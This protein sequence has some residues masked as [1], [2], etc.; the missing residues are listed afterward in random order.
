MPHPE[1]TLSFKYLGIE[2]FDLIKTIDNVNVWIQYSGDGQFWQGSLLQRLIKDGNIIAIEQLLARTDVVVRRYDELE[3]EY[4]NIP[5]IT[6]TIKK[7][8]SELV[9][10]GESNLKGPTWKICPIDLS[11]LPEKDVETAFVSFKDGA[12]RFN[13]A[14]DAYFRKNIVPLGFTSGEYIRD[15]INKFSQGGQEW[16]LLQ[17]LIV[18][19][20]DERL[21]EKDYTNILI[22]A[23]D[24]ECTIALIWA[25][26]WPGKGHGVKWLE[27]NSRPA[28]SDMESE[29]RKHVFAYSI[30]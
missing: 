17:R 10:E 27:N 12:G 24:R 11:A 2:F 29:E 7:R 28:T 16:M 8:I 5:Y 18:C 26:L 13:V 30:R 21:K 22:H 1:G 6:D 19:E 23:L 15:L 9:R 25:L 14:Y 3:A 20:T 4:S